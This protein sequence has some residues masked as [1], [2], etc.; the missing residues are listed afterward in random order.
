MSTRTERLPLSRTFAAAALAYLASVAATIYLCRSMPGGMPMSGGWTM[1]MAWMKMPGQSWP[2]SA[3][4]FIAMW[5]VMMVAMM[6]PSHVP[7]LVSYRRGI[8]P[9]GTARCGRLTMLVSAGYFFAWAIIGLAV[10]PLGVV[11]ADAAMRWL[12]L[13][14]CVPVATGVVLMLAGYVQL[15][16]WKARQLELCGFVP[17]CHQTVPPDDWSACRHGVHLGMQC[18]LCCFNCAGSA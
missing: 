18:I 13:A 17:A 6:L 3:A 5:A 7:M 16:E 10:Y 14:R 4:G 12:V 2:G 1:S 11:M 9:A 15:T 8:H